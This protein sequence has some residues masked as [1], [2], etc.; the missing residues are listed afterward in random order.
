MPTIV[1]TNVSSSPV[2]LRDLY[3]ELAPG[4]VSTSFRS[5][6]Q[7]QASTG[8]HELVDDGSVTLSITFPPE[9]TSSGFDLFPG[10]STSALNAAPTIVVGN[11]PA[12]D[13]SGSF[14]GYVPDTGNGAGIAQA[15]A[16]AAVLGGSVHIRRGLYDLGAVG[17][18][19]LPLAIAGFRVTGDGD[20][21]IIRMSTLDRRL[22]VMTTGGPIGV[23]GAGPEL[24]DIGIDWTVAAPGAVGTE[25]IDAFGGAVVSR[26]A[27]IENVEVIKNLGGGPA[28]P[29]LNP[30][31]SL[32]SLFRTGIAGRIFDSKCIN[33]D[34]TAGL[35]VV[36]FRLV[37]NVSRIDQCA[38]N[39]TNVG[40]RVESGRA[41]VQGCSSGGG[42]ITASH[43]GIELA[44]AGARVLGNDIIGDDGIVAK[45]GGGS[46][47]TGN[48]ILFAFADG[49][50][51]DLG[52]TDSIVTSNR[53]NG[54]PLVV[55]EPSA[56]VGLNAL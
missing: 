47:I 53:M 27:T 31:E 26:R 11:V 41:L 9:E 56:V 55:N 7:L 39:G 29:I 37:G 16:E 33:I 30:N 32:T 8:I 19:A 13:P 14:P 34:G 25:M 42:V 5:S 20:S 38:V 12:G 23:N 50:R 21:T 15:L 54:T 36:A 48:N 28:G 52:A 43:T 6:D 18:P 3:I 17:A 49:I 51:V 45:T 1:V 44:G 4:E 2:F 46:I 24:A 35:T 22:F 40:Y 10:L